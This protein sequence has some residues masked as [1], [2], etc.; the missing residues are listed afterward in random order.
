MVTSH[1]AYDDGVLR[2]TCIGSPASLAIAGDIDEYTCVALVRHAAKAHGRAP[3]DPHQP[4]RRGV[5]RPRRAASHDPPSWRQRKPPRRRR[6]P[7]TAGSPRAAEN[8]C[9]DPRLGRHTWS[10]HRGTQPASRTGRLVSLIQL[11]CQHA[12]TF[13]ASGDWPPSVAIRAW[14][15]ESEHRVSLIF[16][17]F[18]VGG[19]A[20]D[21]RRTPG[22]C[23][24]ANHPDSS[25]ASH[26]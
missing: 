1:P 20:R 15:V 17:P 9:A 13:W 10:G 24:L 3:R 25:E 14:C 6:P 11:Q 16:D 18:Q 8:H 2:I 23:W 12:G 26:R 5:L 19:R 22:S 7:R 21:N 4:G